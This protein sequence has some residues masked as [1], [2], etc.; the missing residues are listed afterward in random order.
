MASTQQDNMGQFFDF[1]GISLPQI[2]EPQA[3][4]ANEQPAGDDLLPDLSN[5]PSSFVNNCSVHPYEALVKP[6][7]QAFV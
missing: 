2:E 5:A 3:A 4:P 6:S 1:G 7:W